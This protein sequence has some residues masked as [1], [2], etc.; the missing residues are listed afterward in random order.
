MCFGYN[1]DMSRDYGCA[2]KITSGRQHNVKDMSESPSSLNP[3]F[4]ALQV[5][6]G[7]NCHRFKTASTECSST[8]QPGT[9]SAPRYLYIFSHTD[10]SECAY[11]K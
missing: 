3:G 1:D 5:V 10:V 4:K 11:S 6:L 8:K 2:T 7:G 9:S